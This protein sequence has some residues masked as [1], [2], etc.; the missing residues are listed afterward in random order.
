MKIHFLFTLRMK[1]AVVFIYLSLFRLT[2]L[3]DE[4]RYT[5]ASAV[6]K[7]Q[8]QL[9]YFSRGKKST[10]IIRAGWKTEKRA[11]QQSGSTVGRLLIRNPLGAIF[12]FA[13]YYICL[14]MQCI[15]QYVALVVGQ[16][17]FSP[18]SIGLIVASINAIS[19]SLS[20]YFSYSSASV[21]GLEKSC[22]GTKRYALLGASCDVLQAETRMRKNLVFI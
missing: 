9:S 13:L 5:A 17:M 16:I 11:A 2:L 4:V 12:A 8:R 18:H 21:H 14:E 19:S 20:P 1:I 6:E 10:V 7:I 3:Q 22:M 15:R